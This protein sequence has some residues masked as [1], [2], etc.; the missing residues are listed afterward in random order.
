MVWIFNRKYFQP[1]GPRTHSFLFYFIFIWTSCI[2]TNKH[3]S[4]PTENVIRMNLLGP[5]ALHYF[6]MQVAI[7]MRWMISDY[8]ET[9]NLILRSKQ[10]YFKAN[11]YLICT[12]CEAH[13]EQNK[14]CVCQ[15]DPLGPA[16]TTL[17]YTYF[18]NFKGKTI[19][20]GSGKEGHL[21]TN[22]EFFVWRN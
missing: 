16:D 19:Y 22:L 13:K 1:P 2:H 15:R 12:V 4:P 8:C 20:L 9:S 6:S 3:L 17:L 14:Y 7:F 18:Y 10:N 21:D 11:F 5:V